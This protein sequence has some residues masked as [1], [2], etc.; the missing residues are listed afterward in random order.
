MEKLGYLLSEVPVLIFVMWFTVRFVQFRRWRNNQ[1]L[2]SEFDRR[3]LFGRPKNH[4]GTLKFYLKLALA[5]LAVSAVGVL[6]FIALA[7]FGAA[8]MTVALILTSAMIVH[9]LLALDD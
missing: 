2:F 9:R 8:I 7:P 3:T 5:A 6:E 4:R 1:P